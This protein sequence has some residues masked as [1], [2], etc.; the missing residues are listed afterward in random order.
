MNTGMASTF[1]LNN[2]TCYCYDHGV[3]GHRGLRNKK[4]IGGY[5]SDSLANLAENDIDSR[6]HLYYLS[7]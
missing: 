5:K 6:V 4:P 1:L 3:T 7:T 2:S